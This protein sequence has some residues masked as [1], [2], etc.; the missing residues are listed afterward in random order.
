VKQSDG[1]VVKSR[2]E[3]TAATGAARGYQPAG[4]GGSTPTGVE[5]IVAA[6]RRKAATTPSKPS[7]LTS[8]MAGVDPGGTLAIQL[9][10]SSSG[11]GPADVA[12]AMG[13]LAPELATQP[14]VQAIEFFVPGPKGTGPLRYTRNVNGSYTLQPQAAP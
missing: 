4:G 13:V 5:Q 14:H 7:Q 2:F 10:R 8:P 11:Q 12:V 9:P 1:S 6:V 3:I